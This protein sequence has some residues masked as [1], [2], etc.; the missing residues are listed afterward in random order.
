MIGDFYK[1]SEDNPMMGK[2]AKYVGH[3]NGEDFS[4]FSLGTGKVT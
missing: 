3:L 1:V 2:K 4:K